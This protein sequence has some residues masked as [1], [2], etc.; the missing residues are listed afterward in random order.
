MSQE[1]VAYYQRIVCIG[2]RRMTKDSAL[3][4]SGFLYWCEQYSHKEFDVAESVSALVDYL[5][6]DSKDKKFLMIAFHA[7]TNKLFDELP[8]VPEVLLKMLEQGSAIHAVDNTSVVLGSIDNEKV[9]A[10]KSP[11]LV[12]T[13]EFLRYLVVFLGKYNKDDLLEF[14][15]IIVDE[16]ISEVAEP[17]S[18]AVVTWAASGFA[19]INLPDDIL[20]EECLDIVHQLYLLMSDVIGPVEADKIVHRVIDESLKLEAASRFDPKKFL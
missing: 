1:N 9:I 17:V 6:L 7:A 12:V 11:Q 5:G 8:P 16:A 20:E 13:A 19:K 2:L 14:K 10:A 4:R 18:N 3:I 15:S